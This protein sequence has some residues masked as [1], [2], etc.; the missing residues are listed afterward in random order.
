MPDR[1]GRKLTC[2]A[3]MSVS[4]ASHSAGVTTHKLMLRP[5]GSSRRSH[6]TMLLNCSTARMQP[7]S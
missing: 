5:G 3:A 6:A 7:S 1:A 2:P 4:P